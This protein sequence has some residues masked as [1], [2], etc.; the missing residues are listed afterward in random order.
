MSNE[1][2]KIQKEIFKEEFNTFCNKKF[3]RE[4]E[5]IEKQRKFYLLGI[6]IGIL[7]ATVGSFFLYL[8]LAEIAARE[9]YRDI[10]QFIFVPASIGILL[11]V[12]LQKRYKTKVKNIILPQLL[13]FIG[14]FKQIKLTPDEKILEI[15]RIKKLMFINTFNNWEIDDCIDGNY[16]GLDIQIRELNLTRVTGYGK[17]KRVERIFKGILIK[18]PSYKKFEGYTIVAKN[19][20]YFSFGEQVKLEDMEFEKH[21]DVRSSN[22]IEARFL[23]TTAFMKRMIAIKKSPNLKNITLSFENNNIYIAVHSTKDWFEIPI[24]KKANK[25]ENYR[26]IVLELL[27]ILSIIETLKLE[28]NIGL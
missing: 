18:C 7:I 28:Q 26:A 10:V 21:Y 17:S 25:I 22:Q 8:A 1:R 5:N 12:F 13:R 23:I 4:I 3:G 27:S 6:T 15:E 2:K 14:D 20:E 24:W 19:K 9:G 11:S 16:K